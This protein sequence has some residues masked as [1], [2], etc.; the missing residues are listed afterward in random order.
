MLKKDLQPLFLNSQCFLV[1]MS[2]LE[3]QKRHTDIVEAY[4][5]FYSKIYTNVNKDFKGFPE[6]YPIYITIKALHALDTPESFQKIKEILKSLDEND[7]FNA[8]V[9]E[10]AMIHIVLQAVNQVRQILIDL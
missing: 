6:R 1:L 10:S 4:E 2:Q 5:K 9:T 7:K 8:V 3:E